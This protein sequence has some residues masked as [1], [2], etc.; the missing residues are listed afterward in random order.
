MASCAGFSSMPSA[1]AGG[2]HLEGPGLEPLV[3]DGQAVAI[4][5]EDLEAIPAAV[6]EEE[7]MAAEEV[8]AEA[9]LDQAREAVEALA[10]VGGPGAEE[11]AD[12]RGEHDHGFASPAARPAIAATTRP[13]HSGSGGESKRSRTRCGNSS[14]TPPGL[15]GGPPGRVSSRRSGT[16]RG[17]FTGAGLGAAASRRLQ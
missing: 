2:G 7:E 6:D 12:G 8:L 15:E 3:P 14:S 4:E 1:P 13:S 16:N 5:V 11:G 17:G 9:F 10:H